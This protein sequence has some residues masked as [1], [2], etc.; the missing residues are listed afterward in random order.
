M[1]KVRG[2]R[3]AEATDVLTANI[4]IAPDR[5]AAPRVPPRRLGDQRGPPR[6]GTRVAGAV[7]V[8]RS[9][10]AVDAAGFGRPPWHRGV[11]Q[12]GTSAGVPRRSR[13]KIAPSGG[14]VSGDR[15]GAP[16][17]HRMRWSSA[18]YAGIA[19]AAP[20]FG[21]LRPREVGH[22]RD[23]LRQTV[24]LSAPCAWMAVE[25]PNAYGPFCDADSGPCDPSEFASARGIRASGCGAG[26]AVDRSVARAI[27]PCVGAES[28]R[29]KGRRVKVDFSTDEYYN[30]APCPT[31]TTLT[32]ADG[33]VSQRGVDTSAR[34]SAT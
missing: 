20:T 25:L 22:G 3:C 30:R 13:S 2:A 8:A 33:V 32:I 5:P 26:F 27:A 10:A 21:T 11:A 23:A 16:L 29:R 24:P 19:R 12:S 7:P 9:P 31:P 14:C 28:Y 34:G 15:G 4:A 1:R 18:S 6:P 17:E